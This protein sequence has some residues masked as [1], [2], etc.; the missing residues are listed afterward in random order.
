VALHVHTSPG[1][2]TIGPLVAAVQR[3]TLTPSTWTSSTHFKV[4]KPF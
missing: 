1:G 4:W 2:W 3:H